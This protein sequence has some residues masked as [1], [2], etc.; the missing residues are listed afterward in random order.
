MTT[1]QIVSVVAAVA[2]TAFAYMPKLPFG[3]AN[4]SLKNIQAVLLIRDTTTN[5]EVRKACSA[6]L[7]ALLQ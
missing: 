6:L 7:Q 4:T 5:P 1:L 2:V 3:K